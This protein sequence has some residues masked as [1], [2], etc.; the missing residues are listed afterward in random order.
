MGIV[1][2][3]VL[4]IQL[5]N[6]AQEFRIGSKLLKILNYLGELIGNYVLCVILP[7]INH[8]W[9][10]TWLYTILM[11]NYGNVWEYLTKRT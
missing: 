6:N 3:W 7:F 8:I 5:Q 1:I 4:I 10:K 9:Y 11:S 2:I